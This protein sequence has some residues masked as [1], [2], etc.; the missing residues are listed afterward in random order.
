M[1]SDDGEKS[2][3]ILV[4]KKGN[5]KLLQNYRPVLLLPISSKIFERLIFNSLYKIVEINS[6]PWFECVNQ[7]LSIVYAI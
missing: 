6:L 1:F 4:H 5:K 3:I 7:L 2:N